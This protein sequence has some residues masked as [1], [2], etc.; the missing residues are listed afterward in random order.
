MSLKAK[1]V[2]IALLSLMIVV[3]LSYVIYTEKEH[4]I[5]EHKIIVKAESAGC[6]KCHGY[7]SE[8]SGSGRDPG[9][10]K[11]WEASVHAEQ[12]VGC[13]DCHGIPRAGQGVDIQNPRNIVNIEWNKE[14]GIKTVDLVMKDGKPVE[15]P[16]IWRH[17]GAEIVTAV[18][19]RTCAQ[20]HEKEAKEFFH[21]RHSTAAQFIGS[22]DNFLGRFVEGPAAA[23][24]GCQ[25][26]HGGVI[27][28]NTGSVDGHAPV[29]TPDSWPNTGM[30]RINVDGSWGSCSACH[31]R[32][33]FSAEVAR[34]PENCGKCHMGPDHPQIEI[35]HE[36]KHGIA[37]KKNEHEMKLDMPGGKWILG[38]DYAHAPTCSTCHMGPVAPHGNYAGLELTHDVGSRISWTLRP[39][40]SIQPRGIIAKDGTVILK[41]PVERREDMKQVCLTCHSDNWVNNFYFQ[42][43]Q[44][45]EL[46]NNKYAKPATAIYEFLKKEGM[47]DNVPMN[48]E[49][50]Y[51]F[52]ELWHHE[53][54]RARHGSSMMGP[55]F[56]QWHGFYELSRNFYTHFLP[57]AAELGEKVGKEAEVEKFIKETLHGPDGGDWKKYHQW[58]EGLS[59]EQRKKML[60]WEQKTYHSRK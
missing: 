2:I 9:I 29:Y 31:S 50:D 39:K 44:A 55:D 30:G 43:D 24:N 52:F 21:S 34:R 47:I 11:Q 25:Q 27:R 4:R 45:I 10:V 33:E 54:R 42:F 56:V 32:H 13:M 28:I 57:L 35:Y 51:L 41:E 49:M 15:R 48:E 12:G 5:R 22:I 7:E 18:S 19:P 6:I 20:C 1:Q 3:V 58:S 60:E 8:G 37:F 46:Y 16:D 36:S 26:C 53:G 40:I 59:A 14:T 17:E 38:K 23:I